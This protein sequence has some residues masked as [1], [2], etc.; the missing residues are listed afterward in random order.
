METVLQSAPKYAGI[1][2]K[3]TNKNKLAKKKTNKKKNKGRGE[4]EALTAPKMCWYKN[5][6]VLINK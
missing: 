6:N 1:K 4:K 3:Q 5:T 2:Y